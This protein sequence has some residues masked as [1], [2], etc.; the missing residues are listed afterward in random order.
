MWLI[1]LIELV[2]PVILLSILIFE[3]FLASQGI[4]S[5]KRNKKQRQD[6]LRFQVSHNR[7]MENDMTANYSV[8]TASLHDSG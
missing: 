6:I 5:G 1:R 2:T 8:T 3:A 4:I 7:G